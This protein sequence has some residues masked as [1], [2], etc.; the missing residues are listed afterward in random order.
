MNNWRKSSYSNDSGGDCLETASDGGGMIAPNGPG[1]KTPP[2]CFLLIDV[3]GGKF[4]RDP[5]DPPTGFR[6][7]DGAYFRR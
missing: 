4:A 6:C 1:T 5:A 7:G 2:S 3:K